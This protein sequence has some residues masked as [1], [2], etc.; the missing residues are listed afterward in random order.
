MRWSPAAH[1][2]MVADGVVAPTPS[3]PPS[4]AVPTRAGGKE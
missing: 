4:G 1:G 3:H 2:L